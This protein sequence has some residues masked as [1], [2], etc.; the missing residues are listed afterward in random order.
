[1]L[2]GLLVDLVPY[3]ERY[4]AKEHDWLNGPG[5]VFWMVGN[6]IFATRTGLADWH[7]ETAAERPDPDPRV[8]FGVQ[9]KDGQP[10]GQIG[11]NQYLP[12][13]R[14]AMLTALIGEPAYWN[15][16]YGTDALLLLLD[17][18]FE[19]WDVRKV[20][21]MTMAANPRVMRQMEKTGFHLEARPRQATW[22]AGEWI[23][24]LIYGMLRDD[25]PG[26]AALVARLG[27]DA[28]QTGA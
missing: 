21:L 23:D 3:G 25:W 27:L 24:A 17:Y 8:R 10:I 22:V 26:R 13:S 12:Q 19:W 6:R 1:M 15:G 9:T 4:L 16:G 5:A 28:R 20:W 11:V 18:L 2:E 7:R 14:L